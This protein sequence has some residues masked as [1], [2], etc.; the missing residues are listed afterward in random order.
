MA[1]RHELGRRRRALTANLIQDA[2]RRMQNAGTVTAESAAGRRFA[3]FGP[4]SLMAFPTGSVYGEHWIE[5]GDKTMIA[6]LVT[7]C[8]GMAP[9]HDLGPEPVLRVGNGCVIGRGSHIV[10]HHSIEIG[11]DVFTGP[12]VYITDQNHKYEDIDTPIG[13]QWPVNSAV[14]IGA[15]SWLGTGAGAT[16]GRNVVIA[17]GSVVRGSVPDNCVVAGVPARVVRQ[18]VEGIGWGRPNGHGPAVPV[19]GAVPESS[20]A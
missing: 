5:V 12:Y 14:K 4:G 10:A 1:W 20:Q 16:I 19:Q 13:R 7:M 15:G 2:W 9:G 18:H 8:A 3:A 17:A 11:D 6:E